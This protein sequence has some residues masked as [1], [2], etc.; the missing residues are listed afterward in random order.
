MV[1]S[2][3]KGFRERFHK[4]WEERKALRERTF[5]SVG[6]DSIELET[7]KPYISSLV[8]FFKEREK[9]AR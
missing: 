6:V 9:R 4:G 7:G 5:A 3:G 2:A 1:F 8:R